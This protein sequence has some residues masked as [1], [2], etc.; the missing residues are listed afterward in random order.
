MVM[1]NSTGEN[2][3]TLQFGWCDQNVSRRSVESRYQELVNG[4]ADVWAARRESLKR[5]VEEK[6]ETGNIFPRSRNMPE[7]CH[8][9]QIIRLQGFKERT[10]SSTTLFSSLRSGHQETRFSF[11]DAG[12]SHIGPHVSRAT[13]SARILL[14]NRPLHNPVTTPRAYYPEIRGPRRKE[15]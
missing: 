10:D 8:I 14:A 5:A 13:L 12:S 7:N 11:N 2:H 1:R 9:I 15:A 3:K 4:F 6:D